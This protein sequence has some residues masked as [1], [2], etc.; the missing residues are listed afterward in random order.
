MWG[1]RV[2]LKKAPQ[3]QKLSQDFFQ[4]CNILTGIRYKKCNAFCL[5]LIQ[6]N[7]K[8][9]VRI[10]PSKGIKDWIPDSLS[11]ELGIRIPV[12]KIPVGFQ[13]SGFLELHGGFQSQELILFSTRK[14]SYFAKS[15]FSYIGR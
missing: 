7:A 8:T 11:V 12:D 2:M 5:Q 6:S 14:K 13:S 4:D 10:A 15:G 1:E 3:T 9:H